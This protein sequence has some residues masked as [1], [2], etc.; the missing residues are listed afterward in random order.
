MNS[1]SEDNGASILVVDDQSALRRLLTLQLNKVGYVCLEA[2]NGELALAAI[3]ATPVTLVLL[4]INMPG[5]SGID[6]LSEF[7]HRENGPAVIML[8]GINNTQLAVDCLKHGAYDYITKPFNMDEV[9]L[10]VKMALEKR[11]LFLENRRY[12]HELE[13]QVKAQTRKV[14]Y[15]FIHAIE[16]LANAQEAK[17]IYTQGHSIRVAYMAIQVARELGLSLDEQSRLRLA[18]LIHDIGKIGIRNDVLNK[19]GPLTPAEFQEVKMHPIIGERIL[20]PVVEDEEVV[21][22]VLHHHERH[23]GSGY[24][25]GLRGADIPLG[26]SI[27]AVC[28]A[29][30]AMTSERPYR[31][32]FESQVALKEIE[33]AQ[34][35][36]FMPE[37]VHALLQVKECLPTVNSELNVSQLLAQLG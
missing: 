18:G 31:P 34:G 32:L 36:Q 8:T 22:I 27:L 19:P 29:Y 11:Q 14:R 13:D 4:D 30:D 23:D 5:R 20:R 26:A 33:K 3:E 21:R 12:Q 15:S 28:D 16:S 25:G 6:L 1:T 37:A 17:D 2:S 9:L 35:S 24:P 7:S 10:S